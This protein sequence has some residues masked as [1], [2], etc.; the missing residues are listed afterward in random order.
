MARW[1][2]IVA[3]AGNSAFTAGAIRFAHGGLE[4]VLDIVEQD[5]RFAATDLDPYCAAAQR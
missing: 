4:D 3:G 5:E 2:V 1:D